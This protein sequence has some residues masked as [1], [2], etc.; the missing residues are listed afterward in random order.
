MAHERKYLKA[1]RK[2]PLLENTH[3]KWNSA[4]GCIT[5]EVLFDKGAIETMIL[6]QVIGANSIMNVTRKK[7]ITLRVVKPKINIMVPGHRMLKS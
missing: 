5:T 2:A 6:M 3:F 4:K 7:L 1:Q